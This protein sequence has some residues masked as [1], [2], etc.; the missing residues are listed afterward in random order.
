MRAAKQ[1]A[2][3]EW[4]QYRHFDIFVNDKISLET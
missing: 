3:G 2:T 1:H 4:L